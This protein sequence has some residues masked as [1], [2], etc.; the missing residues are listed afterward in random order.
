MNLSAILPQ[1]RRKDQP[2][3]MPDLLMNCILAASQHE[4]FKRLIGWKGMSV[5]A[6]GTQG[7]TAKIK[8]R[9][10]VY[11]LCTENSLSD[12]TGHHA[13]IGIYYFPAPEEKLLD[14]MSIVANLAAIQD[15]YMSNIRGFSGNTAWAAPFRMGS[16]KISLD[17]AEDA[18]ALS[19]AADKHKITIARDGV[20]DLSGQWVISPGEAEEDFPAHAIALDI[21][22]ALGAAVTNSL[23]LPTTWYGQWLSPGE[24]S[25]YTAQGEPCFLDMEVTT[26]TDTFAW[27]DRKAAR[28]LAFPRSFPAPDISCGPDRKDLMPESIAQ[29]VLWKTHD[30]AA[31]GKEEEY[32]YAFDSRPKLIVLS[33]FLGSG[34]TT[35]LNQLLEYHASRDELVAIIQ[36][37]VGQTGVDGKLLEGD[38][39]IV[40]LDEGCVCCT[41]AG[42]ISRGVEQLRARFNPKVIVLETTGLAN[43]FNILQEL[44]KLRPLVRLE[45]ITTLVD[46]PNA[47]N[48]LSQSDIARDQVRAADTI[49]LN[50][51]DL[52]SKAELDEVTAK[53][54]QLNKRAALIQ[55]EYGN[56][57][58]GLLYDTD[59][60]KQSIPGLLPSPPKAPHHDH[61]MEGYTSRRFA[62]T[63]PL[64]REN[65]IRTLKNL[66]PEVFRLKGIVGIAGT[67]EAEV[68][69]YV[70]GR[71]ELSR[72]GDS[73]EDEYFLV[74]IGKN[75][76]LSALDNLQEV[77]A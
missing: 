35:F 49:L 45:S 52:T 8:K 66:P 6:K 10:G 25:C 71:Y 39:S 41:L 51:C 7:W 62:F 18:L 28:E 54:R 48:L 12:K 1:Q 56:A 42:S 77:Y 43:P 72:L 47:L 55:T 33:G 57:K 15:E 23:E 74:A 26:I 19:L 16:L 58:P 24:A 2:V 20:A 13:D 31:M 44:D 22:L 3:N 4:T 27:G 46:A 67:E 34:K 29:A 5:C 11:G 65:L 9:P 60:L 40:E 14:T 50:K 61:T 30:L 70:A 37:E 64:S 38:D 76:D 36:N 32:A 75:M 53:L 59:T 68:V 21:V 69:Q 17:F 63:S 73:F